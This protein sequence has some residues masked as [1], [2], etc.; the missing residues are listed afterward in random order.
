M[1]LYAVRERNGEHGVRTRWACSSA[2]QMP[3]SPRAE[4]GTRLDET[5]RKRRHN[6]DISSAVQFNS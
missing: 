5:K 1:R 3:Y 6:Q 4:G 2:H